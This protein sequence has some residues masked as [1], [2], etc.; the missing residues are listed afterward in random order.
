MSRCGQAALVAPEPLPPMGPRAPIAVPSVAFA[1][2]SPLPVEATLLPG[3]AMNLVFDRTIS[4]SQLMRWWRSGSRSPRVSTAWARPPLAGSCPSAPTATTT[5]P[6]NPAWRY[7]GRDERGRELARDRAMPTRLRTGPGSPSRAPTRSPKWCG[8]QPDGLPYREWRKHRHKSLSEFPPM[9]GSTRR[10]S[11][12]GKER[13]CPSLPAKRSRNGSPP[14]GSPG[15][16]RVRDRDNYRLGVLLAT[17]WT[18]QPSPG[19][20]PPAAPIRGRSPRLVA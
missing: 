9:S 10:R 17:G 12:P 11:Q 1:L 7:V 15:R 6:G 8:A 13:P 3:L 5:T 14:S 16:P 20:A 2:P 4:V 18:G 19:Q